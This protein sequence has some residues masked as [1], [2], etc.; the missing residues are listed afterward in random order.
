[1]QGGV[2]RCCVFLQYTF[3]TEKKTLLSYANQ[4][5]IYAI[6]L[7]QQNCIMIYPV[8]SAIWTT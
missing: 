6:L 1:M 5:H 8:I 4:I 2:R 3:K 7:N